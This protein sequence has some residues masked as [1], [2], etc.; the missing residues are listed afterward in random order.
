DDPKK[1]G[2]FAWYDENAENTNL[3]GKKKPNP[4]GL[5]DMHGNVSEWCLDHYDKDF[6]AK[7][8]DAKLTLW[9]VNP[10]TDKRFSHVARGGSWAEKAGRLRRPARRGSDKTWIQRDPQRPQSI[11][12]LTDADFVGFRIVRPV[13]E[14]ENLKGLK[15]KVTRESKNQ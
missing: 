8:K 12:W 15:S 13:E 10:P 5:Y 2:D 4:W 7:F 1:A 3:V 9:P 11:W 6:Y 14:Q